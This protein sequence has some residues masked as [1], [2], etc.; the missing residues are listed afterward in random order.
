MADPR[1]CPNSFLSNLQILISPIFAKSFYIQVINWVNNQNIMVK[2]KR[3]DYH[4]FFFKLTLRSSFETCFS[5]KFL[6]LSLLSDGAHDFD[7]LNS[8]FNFLSPSLIVFCSLSLFGRAKAYLAP[9]LASPP[10]DLKPG[11]APPRAPAD[12]GCCL[13]APLNAGAPLP[14]RPPD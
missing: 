14:P 8:G 10:L 6:T 12:R 3:S 1:N 2:M 4:K 7:L 13:V 11:S 9:P 5:S